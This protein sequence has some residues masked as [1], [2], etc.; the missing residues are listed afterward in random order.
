MPLTQQKNVLRVFLASPSDL[1]DE[2][3]ATKEMVDRLNLTIRESGWT[4]ELL[5]WEDRLPGFGRPQAQINADVDACDL[6]LGVLYRRWGSPSGEFKSGFEE[7]FE[8]AIGRRKRSESP[9]IWIY[10][11]RVEDASDPGEQLQQVLVFRKKL[12]QRRELLFKEFDDTSEW[13]MV[14]HDALLSYVLKRV[15][16]GGIPEVQS[17]ASTTAPSRP[18]GAMQTRL[19][20]TEQGLPEQLS[21][22]SIAIGDAA[23]EPGSAQFNAQ[24]LALGDV[25]LVRLHLLGASLMYEG[26]SQDILSNHAANLVYRHR[27][28]LGTLT[29]VERRLALSSLLREG[30]QNIPGWY[31]VRN[32]SDEKMAQ[33]LE[34]IAMVHPDEDVRTST[35]NLLSSRPDLPD[36]TRTDGLVDAALCQPSDEMRTAALDYAARYGDSGTADIIV[37]RIKDRPEAFKKKAIVAI[38]RILARQD[39]ILA[40]D[41]LLKT[42]SEPDGRLLTLIRESSDQLDDARLHRM[43]VHKSSALRLMA[44][45]GLAGK[46]LLTAEEAKTL[47]GDSEVKVRAI[48]IRRLI[49]LGERPTAGNIRELLD[50]DSKAQKRT[51]LAMGLGAQNTISSDDLVE[52]LFSTLSYDELIPLVSWFSQDGRIAYKVLGLIHFDRFGDKIRTDMADRFATFYEAEK[53]ALRAKY[54][55]I[56]DK[57]PQI[58][59]GAS[60]AAITVVENAVEE[61]FKGWAT[62]DDFIRSTFMSVGLAALAKNGSVN[63][64][65]I[66]RQHLD[67]KDSASRK[68]A[69]EMVA[70]FGNDADFEPLLALA[71][72]EYGDI[73]KRAAKTALALS[74]DR[75]IRAKQYVE[76]EAMPFLRV[77]TDALG[78]HTEFPS[79][80]R[81]LVPYLFV[82]NAS[83]RLATAKLLCSRLEDGDLVRLLN[84]CLEEETYYYDVVA[85]LDRSIYGPTAWRS[86]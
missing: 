23:K 19:S 49:A 82:G 68:A 72:R 28:A 13:A 48:G 64:L 66:A 71:E 20:D 70:K 54:R 65:P 84:Q 35:L 8:R 78:E 85:T 31:W 60:D 77:G 4:V 18:G 41:R 73:A 11:K 17:T 26:V 34:N 37:S 15:F 38:G 43:L 53:Y 36:I 33:L 32:M 1:E 51:L 21:R 80:W 27:N 5:G 14:C 22:V 45:E 40:L 56:L 30:N 46:D 69:L 29:G 2:R 75:W 47:L 42:S 81:E 61:T 39:P 12:E 59:S 83:V 76:R 52:E 79:R 50:N 16:P 86:T 55:T 24:L 57:H 74:A 25:D 9:E 62:L 3:K 6:F 10:F 67:S 63:D 44:A 7:E 58:E